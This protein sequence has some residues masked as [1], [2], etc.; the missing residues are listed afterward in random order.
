[1]LKMNEM[2]LHVLERNPT[3]YFQHVQT[4]ILEKNGNKIFLL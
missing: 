4:W 1:M 3:Y 2:D